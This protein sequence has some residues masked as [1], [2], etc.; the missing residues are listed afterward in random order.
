MER[1][2]S[3]NVSIE[4]SSDVGDDSDEESFRTP[5]DDTSEFDVR[6]GIPR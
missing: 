2:C 5:C 6:R 3:E 1:E 4:D